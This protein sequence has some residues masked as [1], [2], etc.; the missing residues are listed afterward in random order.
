[1]YSRSRMH[2]WVV[3][4]VRHDDV[5]VRDYAVTGRP[6][7]PLPGRYSVFVKVPWTT[8]LD[9]TLVFRWFV[10][11]AHGNTTTIGFHD[12]P[13]TT[14]GVPIETPSQLGEPLGIGGCVRATTRNAQWLYGRTHL[15]DQVVVLS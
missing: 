1:M 12:I 4:H 8:T 7:W 9:G 15:G 14:S 2:V 10:G 13:V 6:D 11:F 3:D 5:V